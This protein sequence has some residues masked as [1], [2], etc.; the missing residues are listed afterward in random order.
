MTAEIVSALVM[1]SAQKVAEAMP[2]AIPIERA[3]LCATCDTVH[4]QPAGPCPRC[5]SEH[6]LLLARLLERRSAA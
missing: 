6:G 3:V 4:D 2:Q 5:T 1:R